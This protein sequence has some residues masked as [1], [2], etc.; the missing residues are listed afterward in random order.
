[1]GH[2]EESWFRDSP[3]R[4]IC[5]C[6]RCVAG[7][8]KDGYV[9]ACEHGVVD[10]DRGVAARERTQRRHEGELGPCVH[11]L[12]GGAKPKATDGRNVTPWEPCETAMLD[13]VQPSFCEQAQTA[14]NAGIHASITM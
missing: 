1:V 6:Q 7:C 4:I 5:L 8:I 11:T 14:V 10:E 13:A 2:V 3:H 12:A 9:C